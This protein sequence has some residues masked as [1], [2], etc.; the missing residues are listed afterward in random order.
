MPK[1]DEQVMDEVGAAVESLLQYTEVV[2]PD[3]GVRVIALLYAG[4]GETA[5]MIPEEEE[6]R[7]HIILLANVEEA[8]KAAIATN[9][10]YRNAQT[11]GE[12]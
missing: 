8:W 1:S 6:E 2:Y 7:V 10:D 11:A 5:R 9:K 3:R 4:V 12:I